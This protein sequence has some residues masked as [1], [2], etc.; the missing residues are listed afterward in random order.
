MAANSVDLTPLAEATGCPDAEAFIAAIEARNQRLGIPAGIAEMG[1]T[2]DRVPSL[3]RAAKA[4]FT[5]ATNARPTS[6]GDYLR[7]FET[8]FA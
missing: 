1:V 8:Q 5:D 2:R 3:A 7:L 6:E 4:D